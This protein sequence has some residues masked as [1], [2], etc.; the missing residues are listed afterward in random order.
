MQHPLKFRTRLFMML[1]LFA[2]VPAVLV[3]LLWGVTLGTHS[4][5]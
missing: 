3:T 4:R 1:S 5:W 2:L